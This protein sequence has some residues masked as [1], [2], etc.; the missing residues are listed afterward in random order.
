MS[1]EF[2][3]KAV[4]LEDKL[5]VAIPLL[6]RGI[7]PDAKREFSSVWC[8]FLKNIKVFEI[9]T[10]S[11]IIITCEIEGKQDERERKR[12]IIIFAV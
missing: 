7:L 3:D 9:C 6:A 10:D 4:I 1:V 12:C 11:Y 5:V 8:I 2:G